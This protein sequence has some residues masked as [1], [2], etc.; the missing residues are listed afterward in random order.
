V[1][2]AVNGRAVLGS[3]KG[4]GKKG[5][6]QVKLSLAAWAEY[7]NGSIA[8]EGRFTVKLLF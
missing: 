5:R 4:R 1:K 2:V 6:K 7:D 3:A 8:A